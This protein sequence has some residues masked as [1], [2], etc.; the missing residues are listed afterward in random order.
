M[1]LGLEMKRVKDKNGIVHYIRRKCHA[2]LICDAQFETYL[3]RY[4]YTVEQ[5]LSFEHAVDAV[6]CIMCLGTASLRNELC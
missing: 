4:L 2:T 3:H 1:P 5:V 6:T